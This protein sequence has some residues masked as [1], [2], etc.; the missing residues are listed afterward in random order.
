MGIVNKHHKSI[1]GVTLVELLV[2]MIIAGIAMSGMVIAYTDGLTILR[3]ATD[4]MVL[5]NEGTAALSVIERRVRASSLM[6]TYTSIGIP[7]QRLRILDSIKHGNNFTDR[8][9]QFYYYPPDN[10]VRWNDNTGN[11]GIFNQQLL[12]LS[13]FSYPQGGRPYLRVEEVSFTPID[14]IRPNNMGTQG[15]AMVKVNLVLSDSRGDTVSL[16]SIMSKRNRSS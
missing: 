7:S 16:S 13:N 4:K 8:E 14:S 11:V 3:R 6:E 9:V 2:T 15:F 5:F 12:P 1:A 10:S